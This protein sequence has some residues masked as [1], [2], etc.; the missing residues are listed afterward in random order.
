MFENILIWI[1]TFFGYN[2]NHIKLTKNLSPLEVGYLE[3]RRSNPDPV[4]LTVVKSP[5]LELFNKWKEDPNKKVV[6]EFRV[7]FACWLLEVEH[8]DL[9]Q[10][11]FLYPDVKR[12]LNILP[13]KD[14]PSFVQTPRLSFLKMFGVSAKELFQ[15]IKLTKAVGLEE[16]NRVLLDRLGLSK[17]TLKEVK[18]IL[19]SAK[20]EILLELAKVDVESLQLVL[21]VNKG[22]EEY[23]EYTVSEQEQFKLLT[24]KLVPLV[25]VLYK[26]ALY[27]M[28][29]HTGKDIEKAMTL[30]FVLNYLAKYE[31]ETTNDNEEM[32]NKNYLKNRQEK[33]SFYA[34]QAL[35]SREFFVYP[36]SENL[37]TTSLQ[38]QHTFVVP[39]YLQKDGERIHFHDANKVR[40]VRIF[41]SNYNKEIGK[42]LGT[43]FVDFNKVSDTVTLTKAGDHNQSAVLYTNIDVEDALFDSVSLDKGVCKVEKSELAKIATSNVALLYDSYTQLYLGEFIFDPRTRQGEEPLVYPA[44]LDLGYSLTMLSH[45]KRLKSSELLRTIKEFG[46]RSDVKIFVCKEYVDERGTTVWEANSGQ[47]SAEVAGELSSN[48]TIIGE[49][50][51]QELIGRL[52]VDAKVNITLDDIPVGSFLVE[53]SRASVKNGSSITFEREK[54]LTCNINPAHQIPYGSHSNS[55]VEEVEYKYPPV[56][57][58]TRLP[59]VVKEDPIKEKLEEQKRKEQYV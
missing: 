6:G 54:G 46:I 28:G 31:N 35:G 15:A 14:L 19:Y 18:E 45:L 22:V 11:F 40:T 13:D 23:S 24:T 57:D 39:A 32:S 30:L 4:P 49:D 33:R 41:E 20:K 55:Y 10:F 50:I 52:S 53:S 37:S 48:I 17:F 36:M 2:P 44:S 42:Y 16:Q 59:I 38:K 25:D 7:D 1:L 21:D 56:A 51:Y 43:Y 47:I 3:E 26:S 12:L 27:G 5:I 9:E 34:I 29:K 58:R 8:E